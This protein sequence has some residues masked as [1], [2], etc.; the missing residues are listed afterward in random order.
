MSSLIVNELSNT[1]DLPSTLLRAQTLFRRFE[2]TVEAVDKRNNFPTPAVR[3]RKPAEKPSSPKPRNSGATSAVDGR[4]RPSSNAGGEEENG[5]IKEKVISPELRQL[6][7]RKVEVLDKKGV[8]DH[9]GGV[10]A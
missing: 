9:E 6:R 3:Q 10:G 5:K 7:S 1:I 8:K 2:R 4:R